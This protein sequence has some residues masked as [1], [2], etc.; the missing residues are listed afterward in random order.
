MGVSHERDKNKND[1]PGQE[2]FKTIYPC[3]NKTA[4]IDCFTKMGNKIVSGLIQKIKVLICW[5]FLLMILIKR[6]DFPQ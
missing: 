3:G 2:T 6:L 1:F 5:L 4:L